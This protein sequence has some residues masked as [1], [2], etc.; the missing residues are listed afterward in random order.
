MIMYQKNNNDK[1]TIFGIKKKNDKKKWYLKFILF[2][3]KL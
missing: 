1:I 2:S 3:L